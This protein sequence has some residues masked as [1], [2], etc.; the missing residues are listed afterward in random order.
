MKPVM[1]QDIELLGLRK[2]GRQEMMIL[3]K[4]ARC[5]H[6]GENVEIRRRAAAAYLSAKMMIEIADYDGLDHVV[7][8]DERT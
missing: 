3:N 2:S 7:R 4:V 1:L 6:S 8:M 5:W